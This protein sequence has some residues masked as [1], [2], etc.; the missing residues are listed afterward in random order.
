VEDSVRGRSVTGFLFAAAVIGGAAAAASDRGLPVADRAK[1]AQTIVVASVVEVTA[2]LERN[3][4]GDRIIV[5]HALL[6]VEEALKGAAPQLVPLDVEGG[7][8][9]DL[10]MQV[11]DMDAIGKGDR[12]V[13]FINR[14]KAGA[15]VPHLRGNGIIKLDGGNRVRGS[16]ATLDDVK[17]LVKQGAQ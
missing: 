8:V 16:N 1:G 7:T 3:A 4:Y 6:R 10:T 5:S 2:A 17:R 11:S 14:S 15:N 12:G 13:F 9:G